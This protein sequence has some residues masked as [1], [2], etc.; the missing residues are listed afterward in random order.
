MWTHLSCLYQDLLVKSPPALLRVV[1]GLTQGVSRRSF[2]PA[3]LLFCSSFGSML[4]VEITDVEISMHFLLRCLGNSPPTVFVGLF[5]VGLFPP[6]M[7]VIYLLV[8]LLVQFIP[9]LLLPRGGHKAAHKH[10]IQECIRN[11]L[12]VFKTIQLKLKLQEW[13]PSIILK[14]IKIGESSKSPAK[15]A[16]FSPHDE[17]MLVTELS[18]LQVTRSSTVTAL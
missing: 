16:L 14:S 1:K 11:K 3:R 12:K 8:Y 5:D 6:C 17:K 9:S 15:T 10:R 4:A 2:F 18:G 7:W 13:S